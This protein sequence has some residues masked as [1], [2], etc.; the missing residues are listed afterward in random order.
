MHSWHQYYCV[1]SWLP[2]KTSQLAKLLS[3]GLL[4][5]SL[6]KAKAECHLGWHSR[7]INSGDNLTPAKLHETQPWV[8]PR[9]GLMAISGAVPISILWHSAMSIVSSILRRIQ[10]RVPRNLTKAKPSPKVIARKYRP[11]SQGT[12]YALSSEPLLAALQRNR[13][14]EVPEEGTIVS[15]LFWTTGARKQPMLS[16]NSSKFPRILREEKYI[17]KGSTFT[18]AAT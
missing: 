7:A 11:C 2:C 13:A 12:A 17:I 18:I 8:H 15:T 4:F 10:R 9:I 14:E 16:C 3:T 5:H 1:A 6:S